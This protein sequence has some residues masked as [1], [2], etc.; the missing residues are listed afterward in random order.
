MGEANDA[1]GV[2][3]YRPRH[4][5]RTAFYRIFESHFDAYVA[6]YEDRFE[7]QD[8]PLRPVVRKAVEAFLACGRPEGGFARLRCDTCG[9][10]HT[11][12]RLASCVPAC[13]AGP[14]AQCQN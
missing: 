5:E 13:A 12:A 1:A 2:P 4:P 3:V 8:G 7:A 11:L 9:A 6:A 14:E 10:E